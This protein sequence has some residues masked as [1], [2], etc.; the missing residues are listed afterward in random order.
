MTVIAQHGRLRG[1]ELLNVGA[2]RQPAGHPQLCAS[3]GER[4]V[5]HKGSAGR[6]DH[7]VIDLVAHHNF[8][9]H[10]SP[11]GPGMATAGPGGCLW[12]HERS[13]RRCPKSRSMARRRHGGRSQ[14]DRRGGVG[15]NK[16]G[17]SDGQDWVS[18]CGGGAAR[19]AWTL[20]GAGAEVLRSAQT[21]ARRLDTRQPS[22]LSLLP[23]QL[24]TLHPDQRQ[25][26]PSRT[27]SRQLPSPLQRL[28]AGA[29]RPPHGGRAGPA[30]TTAFLDR[31]GRPRGLHRSG[32]RAG[33][34]GRAP[35]ASPGVVPL[36][37]RSRTS[38]RS[39]GHSRRTAG[40]F[41]ARPRSKP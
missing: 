16:A 31:N 17:S 25:L 13:G 34:A 4:T 32:C 3:A 40:T 11:P 14:G 41:A 38:S 24:L 37:G 18:M 12:D 8:V 5:M 2:R 20:H 35:N 9:Y 26:R 30:C 28:T 23:R 6:E 39:R 29:D 1:G 19:Y 10:P 27:V 15:R 21:G 36:R 22:R 7:L 33:Y